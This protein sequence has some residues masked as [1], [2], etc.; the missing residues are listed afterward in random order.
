MV[1]DLHVPNALVDLALFVLLLLVVLL[2]LV[3]LV[4][5]VVVSQEAIGKQP[6]QGASPLFRCR[7]LAL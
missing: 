4:V 5:L 2:V 1:L 6:F 3:V 7:S